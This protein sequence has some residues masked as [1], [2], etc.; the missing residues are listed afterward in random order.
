[1][2]RV[3]AV[4]ANLLHTRK[5]RVLLVT[6]SH[7]K[8]PQPASAEDPSAAA[9][10]QSETVGGAVAGGQHSEINSAATLQKQ[11]QQQQQRRHASNL[12]TRVREQQDLKEQQAVASLAQ[13][14][15]GQTEEMGVDTEVIDRSQEEPY[16]ERQLV[17]Q[18]VAKHKAFMALRRHDS[19]A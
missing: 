15:E 4:I 16:I 19:C 12:T 9:S 14:G 6:P 1:M 10:L 13:G 17:L 8:P 11:Q 18:V 7:L 2:Y 3:D 5:D